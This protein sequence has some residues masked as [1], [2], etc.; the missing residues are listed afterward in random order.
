[1]RDRDNASAARSCLV[2]MAIVSILLLAGCVVF[3]LAVLP[4]ELGGRDTTPTATRVIE[5]GKLTF[6]LLDVGQG[7]SAAVVTPAGRAMVID[8]GRSGER[9]RQEL[10]PFLRDRGVE[11]LDYVV[12]THPDQDHVGGLP[13]L[14]EAMPVGAW[15]DPVISTT[16]QSYERALELVADKGIQ[17]IRARRGMD[18]DLG[19]DVGVHILWPADPLS[20]APGEQ[21]DNN[22]SVVIR[23]SWGDVSF[24]VTGDAEAAAE[25]RMVDLEEDEELRSTFLVVGHHGSASSSS[26]AFLDTVSPEVVLIPVGLNNPYGHPSDEVIQRLRLRNIQVYRTDLDGRIE[27]TTDGSGYDIWTAAGAGG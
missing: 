21:G 6:A 27:V 8:G 3:A 26:S 19:P 14:L 15:V 5:S 22:S 7:L 12:M 25:R 20:L 13:A 9:V 2:I 10:L 4:I 17:P 16:N 11:R 18:L 1:M 24:L 23:I